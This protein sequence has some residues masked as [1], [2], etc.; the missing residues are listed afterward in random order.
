MHGALA[1]STSCPCSPRGSAAPWPITLCPKGRAEAQPPDGKAG[2]PNQSAEALAED[3]A[4]H[5]PRWQGSQADMP[6]G[7]I[8]TNEHPIISNALYSG[9]LGGKQ[10]GLTVL[11]DL[12]I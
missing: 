6:L 1:V 10:S 12:S 2:S 8:T 5:G 7:V 11:R 9:E 4:A 3:N